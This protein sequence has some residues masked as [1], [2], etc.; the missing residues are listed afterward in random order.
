MALPP[1]FASL[2]TPDAAQPLDATRPCCDCGTTAELAACGVPLARRCRRGRQQ[3]PSSLVPRCL[4]SPVPR[5]LLLGSI[6]CR[7]CPAE[8]VGGGA[9][10]EHRSLSRQPPKKAFIQ[11]TCD[12]LPDRPG[13]A[14]VV[15]GVWRESHINTIIIGDASSRFSNNHASGARR[16]LQQEGR[17]HLIPRKPG[18]AVGLPACI[19]A[20]SWSGPDPSPILAPHSCRKKPVEALRDADITASS[21][22]SSTRVNDVGLSRTV[23]IPRRLR[24][25]STAPPAAAISTQP[26]P[27]GTMA[28]PCARPGSNARAVLRAMDPHRRRVVTGINSLPRPSSRMDIRRY[29]CGARPVFDSRLT[30]ALASSST[31]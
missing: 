17:D 15:C 31:L 27:V 6:A 20:A 8:P 9:A 4:L 13:S 26:I 3:S 22:Y 14:C 2:V 23:G 28:S 18:L 25:S 10:L 5:C 1:F 21:A 7:P 12:R 16:H 29:S 19:F 24:P 11:R 30:V